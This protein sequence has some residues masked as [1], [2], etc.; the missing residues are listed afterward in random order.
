MR[1]SILKITVLGY[2][3]SLNVFY[4]N[5]KRDF[6]VTNFNYERKIGFY[7]NPFIRLQ[8]KKIV[9]VCMLEVNL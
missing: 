1:S 3:F 4:S 6:L 5:F 8:I 9:F 2:G 7:Q